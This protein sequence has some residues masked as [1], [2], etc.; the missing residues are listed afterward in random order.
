M[1]GHYVFRRNGVWYTNVWDPCTKRKIK[2]KVGASMRQAEEVAAQIRRQ[3]Q[4][5]EL[6]IRP[7]MSSP[8]IDEYAPAFMERSYKDPVAHR[9]AL[10]ALTL[11]REFAGNIRLLAVTK[12]LLREY[13]DKRLQDHVPTPYKGRY[14]GHARAAAWRAGKRIAKGTVNREIDYIKRMLTDAHEREKIDWNPLA[15][16]KKLSVKDAKRRRCL[17]PEEMRRLLKAAGRSRSR[18]L[19]PAVVISLYTGRRRHDVLALHAR[20]YDRVNGLIVIAKSKKGESERIPV[21][22]G[23]QRALDELYDK[24]PEG[25]L[26]PSPK[27]DGPVKSLDTAFK[28]ALNRAGI[29]DFKWHD[30]RHTAISLM[31]MSGVDYHTIADL[32]GHTTPQMIEDRYGHISPKHKQATAVIFGAYLD[33]VTGA[34]TELAG[35]NPLDVPIVSQVAGLLSGGA[36]GLAG[37]SGK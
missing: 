23:A 14:A 29:E 6:G 8:T 24:S 16:F 12:G 26:F 34:K 4:A 20:N 1:A 19:L 32:V 25:W 21:P 7:R 30:L 28:V 2:K 10:R 11:F 33:R 5:R 18:L 37:A 15:G 35:V 3:V 13:I 27:H 36:D 22:P 31:V 9:K 17:E